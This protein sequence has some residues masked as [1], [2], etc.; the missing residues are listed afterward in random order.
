MK[1]NCSNCIFLLS[2]LKHPTNNL[3]EL[4]G[5]ISEKTNLFVCTSKMDGQPENTA[6]VFDNK[7][8]MCETYEPKK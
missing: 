7:Y 1:N 4:K 6:F 5:Q 3:P 8:G 2:L